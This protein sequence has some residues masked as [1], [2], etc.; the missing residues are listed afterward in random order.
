VRFKYT[1]WSVKAPSVLYAETKLS[2]DAMT[3]YP[4]KSTTNVVSLV[5]AATVLLLPSV[6][7]AQTLNCPGPPENMGSEGPI[8]AVKQFSANDTVTVCQTNIPNTANIETLKI[9][10]MV[11]VFD[12]TPGPSNYRC[13]LNVPCGSAGI[14]TSLVKGSSPDPNTYGI[15]AT[16]HNES[17]FNGSAVLSA[18]PRQIPRPPRIAIVADHFP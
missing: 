15:C 12:Y 10:C 7:C 13:E 8:G 18:V 14:Y 9:Q 1:F 4:R 2:G 16:Y 6:T 5:T 11:I 3:K 17:Q